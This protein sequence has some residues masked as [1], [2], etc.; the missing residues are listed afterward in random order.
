MYLVVKE[1]ADGA[2]RAGSVLCRAGRCHYLWFTVQTNISHCVAD[3]KHSFWPLRKLARTCS[4][5]GLTRRRIYYFVVGV[6]GSL[7]VTAALLDAHSYSSITLL[8]A[9]RLPAH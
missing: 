7:V 8:W 3:F 5:S 9:L 4:D 1:L 6:F 2:K